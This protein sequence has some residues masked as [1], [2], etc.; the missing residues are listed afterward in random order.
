MGHPVPA[1]EARDWLLVARG[2]IVDDQLVTP[3]HRRAWAVAP[4]VIRHVGPNQLKGLRGPPATARSPLVD[5]HGHPQGVEWLQITDI[6]TTITGEGGMAV[7]VGV[8]VVR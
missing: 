1:V 3:N 2:A 8:E 6:I 7:V 5:P 4:V